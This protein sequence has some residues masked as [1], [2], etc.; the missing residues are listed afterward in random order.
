LTNRR[1]VLLYQH[2]PN[3]MTHFQKRVKYFME[4][5][6]Q[7]VPDKPSVPDN[8][9]RVLR[10][11]LLLEEVLEFAEASGVEVSLGSDGKPI[12]I[13]DLNYNIVGEPDIIEVADGLSDTLVVALGACNSFGLDIEPV[14]TEVCNSND[15]KIDGGYKRSDGKWM[16]SSSYKPANLEPIIRAQMQNKHV[17]EY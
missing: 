12:E 10:V 3:C 9:T 17:G 13:E 7:N 6:G 8:L 4:S 2:N 15:S 11:S 14:M 1:F 5:V 16:K